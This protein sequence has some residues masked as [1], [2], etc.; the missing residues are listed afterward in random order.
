MAISFSHMEANDELRDC[1]L[2]G[3]TWL[4]GVFILP[5]KFQLVHRTSAL[6][7]GIRTMPFTFSA[8]LGAAFSTVVAG[9]LKI[10]VIFVLFFSAILQVLG[11]ALLATLPQTVAVPSQ[12][13]GF[14]IIAGFGCGITIALPA[15]AMP[16]IVDAKHRCTCNLYRFLDGAD[17][18]S[19]R[20][21]CSRS[22]PHH[23]RCHCFSHL[24][25]DLQQLHPTTFKRYACDG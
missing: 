5:Q 4:V 11:F 12:L 10:P 2:L 16:F 3:G 21:R 19:C 24:D 9:R 7:A 20:H 23:G 6:Q 8:P 13:Y 17:D 18:A 22:S 14:Q 1:T 25:G 15:V